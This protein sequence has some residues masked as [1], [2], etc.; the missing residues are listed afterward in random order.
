MPL[1]L[2]GLGRRMGRDES[3]DLPMT[4]VF[5]TLQDYRDGITFID[6]GDIY[7]KT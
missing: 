5:C 3:E 1:A 4:I 2:A 7:C 6:Y